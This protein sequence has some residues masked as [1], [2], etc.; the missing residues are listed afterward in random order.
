M[1][2]EYEPGADD[3]MN[4]VKEETMN[5]MTIGERQRPTVRKMDT[6]DIHTVE[7]EGTEYDDDTK[8]RGK[9]ARESENHQS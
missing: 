4:P 9:G 1:A 3:M 8:G 5:Q 2:S 7:R 6:E